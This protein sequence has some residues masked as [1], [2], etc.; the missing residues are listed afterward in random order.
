M[1]LLAE[2]RWLRRL[3]DDFRGR[4]RSLAARVSDPDFAFDTAFVDIANFR[5]DMN[6]LGWV[7]KLVSGR[8][9]SPIDT[10]LARFK[11]GYLGSGTLR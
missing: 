10:A 11:L 7:S 1:K 5:L 4:C 9:N 8:L 6:Q 3:P 2:L